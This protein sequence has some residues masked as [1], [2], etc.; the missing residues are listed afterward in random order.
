M[1]GFAAG[2][3][4]LNIWPDVIRLYLCSDM[5]KIS[6]NQFFNYNKKFS[7]PRFNFP[8]T[9]IIITTLTNTLSNAFR[10]LHSVVNLPWKPWIHLSDRLV[11]IC[12]DRKCLSLSIMIRKYQVSRWNKLNCHLLDK[13]ATILN[14]L[15]PSIPII[16]RPVRRLGVGLKDWNLWSELPS[17]PSFRPIGYTLA[18]WSRSKPISTWVKNE[19]TRYSRSGLA[20]EADD[21]IHQAWSIH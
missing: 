3:I 19:L 21:K 10:H 12:Y 14:S 2:F 18:S 6:I 4:K 20:L 5:L 8:T 17:Q 1:M 16:Y 11:L 13:L 9:G 15:S 7:T